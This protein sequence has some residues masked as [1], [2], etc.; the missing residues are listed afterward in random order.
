MKAIHA[1]G[2]W[3]PMAGVGMVVF[4]MGRMLYSLV[5][6]HQWLQFAVLT[7]LF[8]VTFVIFSMFILEK[9]WEL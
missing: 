9:G 2:F 5:L 4:E 3:V 8:I 6:S 1:L 7:P